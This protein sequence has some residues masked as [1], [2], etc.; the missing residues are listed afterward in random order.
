MTATSRI[1][2]TYSKNLCWTKILPNPATFALQTTF[3]HAETRKGRHRLC[4][5]IDTGQ[6]NFA[7]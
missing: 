2:Y 7:G 6:K 5:I 4:V 3:T 1:T